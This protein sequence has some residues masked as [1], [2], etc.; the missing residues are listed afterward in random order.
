MLPRLRC[1]KYQLTISAGQGLKDPTED[2]VEQLTRDGGA[3]L[4]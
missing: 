2:S 3:T 4:C 1:Q